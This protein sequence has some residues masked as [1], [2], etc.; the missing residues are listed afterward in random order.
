MLAL[1][2]DSGATVCPRARVVCTVRG[3]LALQVDSALI[4]PRRGG[5]CVQASCSFGSGQRCNFSVP[6]SVDSGERLCLFRWIAANAR[7]TDVLSVWISSEA[8]R[9]LWSRFLTRN[10]ALL[11]SASVDPAALRE[12][13]KLRV[14]WSV[15]R[16]SHI[17]TLRHGRSYCCGYRGQASLFDAGSCRRGLIHSRC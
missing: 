3:V 4:A 2:V 9:S 13:R 7:W 15:G 6:F 14:F 5:V 12:G 17:I 8:R 16:S 11:L 10:W 1:R